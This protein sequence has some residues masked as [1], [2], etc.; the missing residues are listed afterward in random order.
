MGKVLDARISQDTIGSV[1][2]M[3]EKVN[4]SWKRGE[5]TQDLAR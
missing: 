2:D 5:Q 3:T 4:G 1:Y